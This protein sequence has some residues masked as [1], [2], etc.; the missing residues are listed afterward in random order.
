MLIL[1]DLITLINVKINL[2]VKFLLETY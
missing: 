1:S 2:K